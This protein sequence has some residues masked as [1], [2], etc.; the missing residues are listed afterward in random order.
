[1]KDP[2]L[3]PL[4]CRIRTAKAASGGWTHT[5]RKPASRD[6]ERKRRAS[7]E[8]ELGCGRAWSSADAGTE[9]ANALLAKEAS[10]GQAQRWAV[11]PFLVAKAI[12]RARATR[13]RSVMP[14]EFIVPSRLG[15][16]N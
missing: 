13:S 4:P 9:A 16:C 2:A 12:S 7:L 8:L 10:L 5:D 15:P 1:M 6:S 11:A 3:V 14:A